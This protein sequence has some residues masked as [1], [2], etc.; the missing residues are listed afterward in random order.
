MEHLH[1]QLET[2]ILHVSNNEQPI[3]VPP[4]PTVETEALINDTDTGIA[5]NDFLF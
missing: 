5:A 2:S 4:P 3:N 1:Q